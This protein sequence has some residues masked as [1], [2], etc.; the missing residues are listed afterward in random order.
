MGI[1]EI[2]ERI[3]LVLYDSKEKVLQGFNVAAFFVSI[4]AVGVIIYLHGFSH[5]E[6]EEVLL[7]R[8]IQGSFLFYVLRYILR[9]IYDFSPKDFIKKN[10][11]EGILMLLLVVDGV[12]YNT[13]GTLVLERVFQELGMIQMMTVTNI[14]LQF[15]IL[16]IVVVEL[17]RESIMLP[18][19]KMNPAVI[20][21]MTFF[22]LIFGGTFL[23]MLPEMTGNEGSM[24]FIDALFTSTSATC[25]TGLI[26]VDTATYFTFKG[27]FIILLLMKLGGLNIISFGSFLA[28]FNK[29]GL[30]MKHH[31]V[32]EDFVFKDSVFSSSGL[33]SKIVLGSI[34]FET[35]GA[36]FMLWLVMQRFPEMAFGEAFF[37][38]VFHAVSAFNNAGFSTMTDGMY[39]ELYSEFFVLHLVLGGLIFMGTLGFDTFFDLFGFDKMRERLKYPWKRPRIGSMLNIYTTF[40]LLVVGV[41][42][43]FIFERSGVMASY[44]RVDSFI[45]A[46]FQTISLRTAGFSS[47]D[48]HMVSMPVIIMTLVLMFI[49]GSS[50]STAGGIKTSTFSIMLLS[51]Y[52]TIR[53]KRN[54]EVFKRTI[55]QDIV[56]RAFSIFM[57]SLSGVLTGLFVLSISESHILAMPDRTLAD[58]LF[59]QVSAF[60]TV[61][62]STGITGMLSD[63]GKTTLVISMFIG[64]VGTLTVAFALS[65]SIESKSYKYPDEHMLVG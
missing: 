65:K 41:S 17:R 1:N 19:I 7:F 50:S 48:F 6:E 28:F 64:R 42:V 34:L 43:F 22:I 23:L 21:I 38:S 39:N 16:F 54:I 9:I 55:P 57:F 63:I 29:F 59:E 53:G 18:R 30:G 26:V 35:V 33:L 36:L 8:V 46:L 3:N 56:F 45:T 52:S 37:F 40:I 44:N 47:V 15:Y 2:R 12:L 13:S 5:T 25:V 60:S 31:D 4:F 51:A 32:V 11:F 49:G 61:G 58:L 62:L 14:F 27:Q 10:W 20:F 24:P